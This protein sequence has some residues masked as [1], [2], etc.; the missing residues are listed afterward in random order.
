MLSQHLS[1]PSLPCQANGIMVTHVAWS[2]AHPNC[3]GQPGPDLSVP[4]NCQ[5]SNSAVLAHRL[6]NLLV[7]SCQL[8]CDWC[9]HLQG[10]LPAVCLA[11]TGLL[12]LAVH[13]HAW[14]LCTAVQ[15]T[16]LNPAVMFFVRQCKFAHDCD[17]SFNLDCS[18]PH[19]HENFL[20]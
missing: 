19:T 5:L 2:V 3:C 6:R 11:T 8:A 20:I 9:S 14:Q 13:T 17:D 1:L 12:C 16:L 15:S 7:H 10:I 18:A 4:A